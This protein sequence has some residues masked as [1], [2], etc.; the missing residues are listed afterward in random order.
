MI[1]IMYHKNE[2]I[3]GIV[4]ENVISKISLPCSPTMRRVLR[5][6]KHRRI[7][8]IAGKIQNRPFL[9]MMNLM[10]DKRAINESSI[11]AIGNIYSNTFA[12]TDIIVT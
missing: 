2:R 11:A 6:S 3:T 10:L 12:S 9:E 1:T 4:F 5:F 7:E 8:M